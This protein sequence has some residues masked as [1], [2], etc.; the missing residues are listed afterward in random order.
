MFSPFKIASSQDYEKNLNKYDVIHFDVQGFIEL[1]GKPEKVVSLIKKEVIAELIE[2]YPEYVSKS[3]KSIANALAR[4]NVAT[5]S[6]FIVIIDEWDVLIRDDANNIKV[7][8]EYISFLRGLFKGVEPSRY[9]ALAYLTGILPIKREKTQ[10][11]LNNFNEYTIL[12]AGPF[13][14]YDGFTEKEVKALS[15]KYAVS[16]EEVRR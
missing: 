2:Y 7:Q 3:E 8:E 16:F 13:A 9:I 15:E 1:A 12:D 11:A 6:Q 14:E 10:S 4:I 5:K